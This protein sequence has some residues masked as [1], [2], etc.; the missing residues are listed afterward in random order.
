[1]AVTYV[2]ASTGAADA[3]GAFTATGM[4][5]AAAG[6]IIILQVLQDGTTD[7]A[8]TQTS[9]TNITA[10]DGTANTWTPIGEYQVGNAESGRQ[11]LWVGRSTGTSAP[12]FTGGNSTSEDVFAR[13]YEFSGVD[14]NATTVA[15]ILENATAGTIGSAY[16]TSTTCSD[17]SVQ[18]TYAGGMALNFVALS[19]D[20]MGLAVFAGMSGGTWALSPD[21]Y[22]DSAGTDGS[23]ALMRAPMTAAGTIDGGS[24]AI[25]SIGWGVI[26]FALIPE[27][28]PTVSLGTPND[29]ATISDTTPD[30]KFTGTDANGDTVDYQVQVDTAV[31]FDIDVTQTS[32]INEYNFK[33]SS[34]TLGQSF[35]AT[36]SHSLITIDLKLYKVLNP[37]DNLIIELMTDSISGA[38]VATS[39]EVTGSSLTT[40]T[41]GAIVPFTFSTPY[42]VTNGNKYYFRIKRTGS[43]D[44]TNYYTVIN[45]AWG[46]TY[47][48]GDMYHYLTDTWYIYN[49]NQASFYFVIYKTPLISALS[50]DHTGFSA[51]ASHPTASGAEQTYTVQTA[52]VGAGP[53]YWR[54]RATDPLGSATWGA[55]SPGDS[56]LGY[57]HFH[58]SAGERRIFIT[59]S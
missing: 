33:T 53:F 42:S 49:E 35:V 12:T 22:S 48:A 38:A 5:P 10:L 37:V 58:I 31:T 46:A 24:D 57:D 25:T 26:G 39:N 3:G 11:Y 52:L 20:A 15:G 54:V 13:M 29:N 45:D 2:N 50:T 27:L 7:S 21:V 43:T 4:A 19:D 23:I 8:V 9:A 17:V 16:N 28:S 40:N 34:A 30:L 55:W 6:N 51:G 44:T 47:L 59:H 1:M 18:T 56:T 41:V 32:G 36:D 14:A